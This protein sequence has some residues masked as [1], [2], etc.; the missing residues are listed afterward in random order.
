MTSTVSAALLLLAVVAHP[1]PQVP[2]A[3]V[4]VPE[5]VLGHPAS[6]I[7]PSVQAV[8]PRWSARA[9]A[10]WGGPWASRPGELYDHRY[11]TW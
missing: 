2:R 8:P 9:L 6:G 10:A 7:D 4:E 11:I 5:A 3:A 1:A